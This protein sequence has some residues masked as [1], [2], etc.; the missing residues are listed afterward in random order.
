MLAKPNREIKQIS[1]P[2]LGY[3]IQ[4]RHFMVT[5]L[6]NLLAQF[7]LFPAGLFTKLI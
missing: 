1:F 4:T 2:A 7:I 5:F 6:G 3:F